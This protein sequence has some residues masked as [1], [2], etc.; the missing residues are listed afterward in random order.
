MRFVRAVGFYDVR[1]C[2]YERA[3]DQVDT[4]WDGG[5]NGPQALIYRLGLA[6]EVDYERRAPRY[7][8]GP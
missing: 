1:V 4:V 8:H 6:G 7:S 2:L 5:E 3:S